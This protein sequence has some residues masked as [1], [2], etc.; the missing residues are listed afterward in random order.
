MGYKLVLLTLILFL[1]AFYLGGCG[2]SGDYEESEHASEN[3]KPYEDSE[4]KH[5]SI[6]LDIAE[7]EQNNEMYSP[8]QDSTYLYWLNNEMIILNGST[9]CNIFVLN[10]LFKAGYRTPDVN[11]LSRDLFDTANFKDILPVIATSKIDDAKRGDIIAWKYHV[12]LFE[13]VVFIKDDEYAL[14]YW[15]GTRQENN[16]INIKN[17]VCY[18][19]YKLTGDYVVRRPRKLR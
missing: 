1:S 18:G 2:A 15:A 10:V 16:N 7:T 5:A 12:I 9:K 11:A 3:K 17:N 4:S 13:S 8:H 19:K 14:G 6:I